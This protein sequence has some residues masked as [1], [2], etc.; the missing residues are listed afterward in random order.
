MLFFK[1][2]LAV[3]PAMPASGDAFED[4]LARELVADGVDGVRPEN[5]TSATGGA[6]AVALGNSYVEDL[7]KLGIAEVLWLRCCLVVGAQKISEDAVGI[8][9]P[10]AASRSACVHV[11]APPWGQMPSRRVA[12]E[13]KCQ[14]FSS[15]RFCGG[16]LALT[17]VMPVACRTVRAAA[18]SNR[19][20]QCGSCGCRSG[21]RC[22]CT[23]TTSR[24]C[25]SCTRRRR[26][27]RASPASGKTRERPETPL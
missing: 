13:T 3:L 26:R 25:C 8:A 16:R 11:G 23:G 6:A 24:R 7:S 27:G 15:F 18:V 1:H 14:P 4:M 2:Q 5:G 21:T 17:K 10:A 9:D 19:Y 20:C 12:A 22:S